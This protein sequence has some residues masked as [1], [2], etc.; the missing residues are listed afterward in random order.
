MRIK[1]RHALLNQQFLVYIAVG[2]FTALVDV[3]A[4]VLLLTAGASL[5]LATTAGF[6]LG[7]GVNQFLHTR[8]TFAAR[9]TL[10]S[11]I[12][13]WTIVGVN[14]GLTLGFVYAAAWLDV[15]AVLGK[16][17]S[18]PVVAM[19]GFLLSKFWAFR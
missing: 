17:A 1:L 11:A 18:L 12:R 8:V 16:L 15:S 14:Y 2:F 5:Q 7:L 3:G 19:N 9:F 13:F 4:M 10:G 6:I